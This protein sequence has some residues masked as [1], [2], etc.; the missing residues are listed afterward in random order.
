[1]NTLH[2]VIIGDCRSLNEIQDESIHLVITSPPY[3]NA[4]FVIK[5]S[6]LAMMSI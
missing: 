4:P 6:F 3:F 2:I 1:M 5:I